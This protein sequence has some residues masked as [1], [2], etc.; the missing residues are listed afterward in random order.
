VLTTPLETG[1]VT[2]EQFVAPADPEILKLT[3]PDGAN[4]FATPVTVAVKTIEPPS[5]G[6]EVE[7]NAIVG[8]PSATAVPAGLA[9]EATAR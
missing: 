4:A 7:F 9:V 6:V 1:P 3:V 2:D 8:F 5:V